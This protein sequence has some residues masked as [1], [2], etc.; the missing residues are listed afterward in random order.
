MLTREKTDII[1]VNTM[2]NNQEDK[3]THLSM[4][5][6]SRLKNLVE[7]ISFCCQE[8]LS[9]LS[10]KF[11]LTQSELRCLLLFKSERYLTVTS[12]AQKLEVAK[13]RVTKVLDG[14][15]KKKMIQ[16][17]DDPEDARIK[18]I[19]LTSLG[20]KKTKEIDEFITD[21]HHH[22]VL[23]LNPEDRNSVIASLEVLRASMETVKE[24]LK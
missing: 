22:L 4:Y 15:L 20:Q 5:Q 6:A 17:F 16:R 3:T 24:R 12:I 8:R 11:S 21:M 23:T 13:S 2:N 14:L 19:S 1:M 10:N 9:L 18:L 7:E